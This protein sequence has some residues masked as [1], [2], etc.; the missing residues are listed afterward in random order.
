[1]TQKERIIKNIKRRRI[2]LEE[3]EQLKKGTY[4]P[5]PLQK[6]K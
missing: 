4:L 5:K 3:L 6:E 2:L 1:M